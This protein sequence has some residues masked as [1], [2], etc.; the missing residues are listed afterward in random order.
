MMGFSGSVSR[1]SG[2]KAGMM[3]KPSKRASDCSFSVTALVA[4]EGLNIVTPPEP[5]QNGGI[6]AGG[7]IAG[8]GLPFFEGVTDIAHG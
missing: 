1:I 2:V 4:S 7:I 5:A 6:V 3:V 8:D